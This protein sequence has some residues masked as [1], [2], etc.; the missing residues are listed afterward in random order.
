MI[1]IW[2]CTHHTHLFRPTCLIINTCDQNWREN[3]RLLPLA[4]AEIFPMDFPTL[5]YALIFSITGIAVEV[6]MVANDWGHRMLLLLDCCELVDRCES[7]WLVVGR[8]GWFWVVVAGF[9]SSWLVVAHCG[10]VACCGVIV[11]RCGSFHVLVTTINVVVISKLADLEKDI[12]Y[13]D[14]VAYQ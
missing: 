5:P 6:L 9:G 14:L 7:L 10:V 2:S 3:A 4:H 8:C 1:T 11:A 12:K 13:I